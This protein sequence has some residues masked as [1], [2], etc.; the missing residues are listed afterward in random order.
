VWALWPGASS[1]QDL[2]PA[3]AEH[4]APEPHNVQA[5]Q[6]QVAELTRQAAYLSQMAETMWELE[7]QRLG[8]RRARLELADVLDPIAQQD[9]RTALILVDHGDRLWAELGETE[10]AI[11]EYRLAIRL[12]PQ[13]HW[14]N[15]ARQRLAE[16]DQATY[17]LPPS[18][19]S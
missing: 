7:T 8:G 5:L 15:V 2:A 1:H 4:A 17:V 18:V 13:T 10:R 19:H 16:L 9:E 12:F 6:A 3:V 14:A 11:E